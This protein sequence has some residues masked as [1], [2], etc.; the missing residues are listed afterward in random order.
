MQVSYIRDMVT[1]ISLKVGRF[2]E[3][4]RAYSN[5]RMKLKFVVLEALEAREIVPPMS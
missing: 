2:P 4:E 3:T 5:L 1:E